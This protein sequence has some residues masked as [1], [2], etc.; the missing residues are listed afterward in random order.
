M[1]RAQKAQLM[2]DDLIPE[3]IERI[4]GM[5]TS[6]MWSPDPSD[7]GWLRYA[8]LMTD[9]LAPA[10]A[11]PLPRAQPFLPMPEHERCSPAIGPTSA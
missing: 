11:N 3:D 8:R 2:R 1:V 6:V 5:P 7:D 10:A 4:L 9:A